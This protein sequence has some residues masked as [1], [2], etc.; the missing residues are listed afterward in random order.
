MQGKNK[1]LV[2]VGPHVKSKNT[3]D[4]MMKDVIIALIPAMVA[5]FIF[6]G[7]KALI[8]IL[9]SVLFC[10]IFEVI[11]L[12]LRR[13]E[14]SPADISSSALTGI[15]FAFCITSGLSIPI[16]I[17]GCFVAIVIAKHLFGGLGFNIFNPALVARAFLLSSFPVAMTSWLRPFDAVT[18]PTPLALLKEKAITVPYVDLFFGNTGGSL[19]ETSVLALLIGVI[20]L[21]YRGTIGWRIPISYISTVVILSLVFGQDPIFHLLAGG[22]ILGAFYM[23]TDLVTSPITKPG[24][25]IFGIGCGII[26]I[27]IRLFGGYPEGVCYSILVMNATVPLLDRYATG[28]IFGT[29]KLF[30]VG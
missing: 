2:S 27:I 15:L 4:T 8:V 20:Y 18:G 29:K 11:C 21:F 14:I 28:R 10:V 5:S 7:F 6:F 30:K 23:A 25:W 24:R 22:L 1:L 12:R 3:S 17:I 9:T 19:G 26:T 13:K 16:V